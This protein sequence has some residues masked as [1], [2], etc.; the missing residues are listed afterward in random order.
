MG[1]ESFDWVDLVVTARAGDTVA[2]RDLLQRF[3]P[4]VQST[5][6]RLID[7][8]GVDDVVQSSFAVALEQLPL[9]RTSA[10]FPA[11]LRLIVRK[12]AS[13][14]RRWSSRDPLG[15]SEPFVSD[16]SDP[17]SVAQERALADDVRLALTAVRDDDRRLLELRYLAG[18]SNADLAGLLR[19]SDGALRKRLHAA[20]RR[21][22]PL[23]EHLNPEIT[24]TDYTRYLNQIHNASVDVP[25]APTLDRP[26][27][28]PTVT[29]L[30]VID[31]MAPVRRCGTVEMVGPAGTG[32]LVVAVELLYRL[33]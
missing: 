24:M 21:L 7:P 22:R 14:Q 25:V 23:L 30:K 17:A 16:A 31:T 9:L 10:A 13:L 20:R 4:L 28:E 15:P 33:G 5:A 6:S 3:E 26:G 1:V 8:D 11:W 12:Q 2:V 27:R 29:G 18:W 19:V 32:Q